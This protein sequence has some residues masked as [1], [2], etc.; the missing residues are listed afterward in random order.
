MKLRTLLVG[1]VASLLLAACGG[2]STPEDVT[3]S[4]V[5]AL[6][7]GK[8]DKAKE[9]AIETA[10]ESVQGTLDAGCESYDTEIKTVTCETTGET[11][12]CK[13]TENR[14]GMDMTYVYNLSKV[15]GTWKVSEFNKDL[16]LEGMDF[17]DM[18]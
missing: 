6:A 17:G 7:D 15:D 13:C 14:T 12:I 1:A 8:C 4:F 5:Q 3:K 16:D 11:S 9:M 18:Q 2:G 10:A